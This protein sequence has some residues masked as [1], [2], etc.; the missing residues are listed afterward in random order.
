MCTATVVGI[1][2]VVSVTQVPF[3]IPVIMFVAVLKE[4]YQNE[5]KQ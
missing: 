4:N 2:F 5:M 3:H 1:L